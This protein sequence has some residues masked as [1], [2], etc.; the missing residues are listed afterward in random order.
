[1]KICPLPDGLTCS[2]CICFSFINVNNTLHMRTHNSRIK[3]IDSFDQNIDLITDSTFS[4][5]NF[6][7]KIH[8]PGIQMISTI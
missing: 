6:D 3:Q 1:M 2:S 8:I 7:Y 5:R 4:A